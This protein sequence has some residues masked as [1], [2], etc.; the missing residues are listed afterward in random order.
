MTCVCISCFNYYDIRMRSIMQHFE[1]KGYEVLYLISDYDHYTKE[2]YCVE[3]KDWVQ[4]S[5]PTYSKNLSASR[6]VSHMLFSE[7]VYKKLKEIKPQLVYCMF[8]PNS[9][10]KAVSRYKKKTNCKVILDC[11][12]LWPESFPYGR[13]GKIMA[14]PF[15][16]WRRLRDRYIDSANLVICVSEKAKVELNKIVSGV[17]IRVIEPALK[18]DKNMSYNSCISEGFEFCYLGNI[19]HITDIELGENLLGRLAKYV[20]VR[21]HIIGEGQNLNEF[22]GKLEKAGV[23]VIKHGVIFDMQ[24]KNRIFS[25]CNF[26]LNIPRVEI[27]SS[28]SLKS[29]EYMRA[30]L[31]FIN[32]GVG[33]NEKIVSEKQLG[34]NI[35]RSNIELTIESILNLSEKDVIAM[36][37]NCVDYYKEHF[38]NQ[39]YDKILNLE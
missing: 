34:I 37:K 31:P 35:I 18:Q 25:K 17:P 12:D 28:M 6:L 19:N 20:P 36:H 4:I 21:V 38:L 29:V 14:V 10:V 8:P 13:L 32:S 22:V 2:K 3:K 16:L 7:K 9:L 11:F 5:V 26:G 15:M 24:E 30:G 27:D 33:D 39:D 23:I 1:E